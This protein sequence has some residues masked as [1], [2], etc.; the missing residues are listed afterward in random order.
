MPIHFVR[1]IGL[2]ALCLILSSLPAVG[3]AGDIEAITKPSQDVTLSF[4]RAGR[5]AS[6]LVE[7]GQ[8]VE[9]GQALVQQDDSAERVQ[10]EQLKSQADDTI[11][12]QAGQAQLE[13]KRL[14]LKKLEQAATRGATTPLEVENA[15][16]EVMIAGL[17]LQLAQFEHQQDRRK[18][19]ELRLQVA[20]MRLVSPVKGR[21]EKIFLRNGEGADALAKVVRIVKIDTLWADVPVPLETA[22]A[23]RV[24]QAARIQMKGRPGQPVVGRV[25]HIAAVAD[26]ASNTLMVRVEMPNPTGQPAG[27]HVLVSFPPGAVPGEASSKPS[28][29]FH[30]TFIKGDHS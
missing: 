5:I 3:A 2:L 28:M 13:Q 1:R 29:A 8:E 27:N 4:V 17:S 30:S 21:V 15:R 19:E 25:I 24:G 14:D 6:V 20:R 23:L 9:A 11:K 12:V 22:Q 16:L 10:M 18:Y 26:A 7:E